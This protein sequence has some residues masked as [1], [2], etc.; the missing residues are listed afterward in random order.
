[1]RSTQMNVETLNENK[2]AAEA[3]QIKTEPLLNE[4]FQADLINKMKFRLGR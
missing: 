3:A 1:M 4:S 2:T